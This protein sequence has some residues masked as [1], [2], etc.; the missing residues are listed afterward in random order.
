VVAV[1]FGAGDTYLGTLQMATGWTSSRCTGSA[2]TCPFALIFSAAQ[3]QLVLCHV[4]SNAVAPSIYSAACE[5]LGSPFSDRTGGQPNLAALHTASVTAFG[6]VS[7]TPGG[8]CYLQGSLQNPV[9][10]GSVVRGTAITGTYH[11][12]APAG[13]AYLPYFTFT[14]TFLP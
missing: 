2:T 1:G 8:G 13:G 5:T 14:A 6:G 7:T 11:C 4:T 12:P 10:V 9:V 3:N